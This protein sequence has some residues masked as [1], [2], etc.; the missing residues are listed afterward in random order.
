MTNQKGRFGVYPETDTL[1]AA[2]RR[3]GWEPHHRECPG[4]GGPRNKAARLCGACRGATRRTRK[5]PGDLEVYCWCEYRT[6]W[7]GPSAIA[8]GV[9]GSCGRPE[10]HS[11]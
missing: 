5:N 1:A 2:A 6:V 10:C 11:P 8:A 3:R 9:T 4:C 7:V